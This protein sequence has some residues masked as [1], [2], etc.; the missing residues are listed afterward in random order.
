ML[1]IDGLLRNHQADTAARQ[2]KLERHLAQ[3]HSE[4]K[5]RTQELEAMA[6][7]LD[8]ARKHEQELQT[9]VE[10]LEADK[11]AKISRRM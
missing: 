2:L 4:I 1:E 6:V 7:Q 10:S 3:R 5:T 8:V 9:L 11:A